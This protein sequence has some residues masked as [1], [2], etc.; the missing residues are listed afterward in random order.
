MTCRCGAHYCYH[1]GFGPKKSSKAIYKHILSEHGSIFADPPYLRKL[2]GE[3]VS[4]D[5]LNE[6]YAKYP[7]VKPT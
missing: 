6:F 1:C 2:H 3:E 4:E 7:H 5:E